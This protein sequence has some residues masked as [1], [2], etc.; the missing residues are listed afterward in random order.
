MATGSSSTGL[1]PAQLPEPSGCTQTWESLSQANGHSC[2]I[3]VCRSHQFCVPETQTHI[4]AHMQAKDCDRAVCNYQLLPEAQTHPLLYLI[5]SLC[6][7]SPKSLTSF[8]QAHRLTLNVPKSSCSAFTP[9]LLSV[10]KPRVPLPKAVP[11][12]F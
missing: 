12:G 6:S 7:L 3:P 5:P 4:Q 9:P 2:Y 8:A 11:G 10:T 1:P